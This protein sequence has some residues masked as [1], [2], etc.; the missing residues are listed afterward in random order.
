METIGAM[1]DT[2]K[3]RAAG[4]LA[5]QVSDSAVA[6]NCRMFQPMEGANGTLSVFCP[7]R[8]QSAC[9]SLEKLVEPRGQKKTEQSAR[10]TH[11]R[12][13]ATRFADAAREGVEQG[14]GIW[15]R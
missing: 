10:L 11:I 7:V 13:G 14:W 15:S 1:L 2:Y 3:P 6:E 5:S 4:H 12:W 9:F 8:A